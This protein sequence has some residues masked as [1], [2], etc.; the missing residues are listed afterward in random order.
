MGYFSISQMGNSESSLEELL[1]KQEICKQIADVKN[2][3][4][5]HL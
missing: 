3:K 1:L 2:A 5:L 4:N